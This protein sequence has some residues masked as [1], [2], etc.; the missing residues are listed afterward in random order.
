[1][2]FF[3]PTLRVRMALLYG[4]LVLLVGVSLLFTCVILLDKAIVTPKFHVTAGTQILDD[5]NNPISL[6]QATD[7]ERTDAIHYLIKT[8]LLY[9]S[10]IIVIGTTGG[11]LLAKQALRPIA[12][13]TQT[14]RQLSTETLDQ[15][16]N[17]GGPDDELRELADTF[18]DMLARLDAAFDSQRLFVANASHELRTPL[19]VIK[20]E[21]EVTLSDPD[22]DPEELRRMA[23]VVSSAA[24]RAQRLV[25]S[26]LTLA[27][28]Q[29]VGGGELEVNE[30]VDLA[31]L[32][33]SALHAV[34]AEAADKGVRIET[35]IEQA[36][37]TGDPRL[38]ER[39]IGNLVENAIRHNVPGG[40]LRITTGQAPEKVWLHVANGGTVIPSGDVDRLF[41]PFRRGAGK[42]R[43]ATRG[44]GLGLAIVR[45]IVEAHQGRLQAAAP[46]FGGLA[47]R[48]ELPR[49]RR[50]ARVESPDKAQVD[51]VA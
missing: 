25:T 26:L 17:L 46:P 33:P 5:H 28:L 34:A 16:I 1:M 9:F 42:V 48:I 39:L 24:E 14:A 38:L 29:A 36:E 50:N 19:S 41:E 51:A 22:A 21:L 20:T 30:P 45:L 6:Q 49:Q 12:K 11:Y 32:V 43:T 31:T 23:A 10:I 13:L 2:R 37:T 7:Q 4:G 35:E 15:R 40:W 3:R 44:A 47:I 8:G 27:R 18:D